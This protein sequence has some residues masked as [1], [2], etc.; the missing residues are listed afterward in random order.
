MQFER[1][2]KN[3]LSVENDRSPQFNK[4]VGQ[5]FY[6][7]MTQ[8]SQEMEASQYRNE[9][10]GKRLILLTGARYE[11]RLDRALK[12]LAEG[13]RKETDLAIA[14]FF[15]A[16]ADLEFRTAANFIELEMFGSAAQ[17]K[18]K[19]SFATDIGVH[20]PPM[21]F[22]TEASQYVAPQP[23]P[24][25]DIK[26]SRP[27]LPRSTGGF[28]GRTAELDR[29]SQSC[30][31]PENNI[32]V[33]VAPGGYGKTMLVEEFGSKFAVATGHDF[34]WYLERSFYSQG[35]DLGTA[36]SDP[37]FEAA[38]SFFGLEMPTGHFA[39]K[40]APLAA[41][42]ARSP[43]LLVL[44]GLEPLQEPPGYGGGAI[45]DNGLKLFLRMLAQNNSGLC[46]VTTRI[47]VAE[48]AGHA[49]GSVAVIE[50]GNLEKGDAAK[51]LKSL[52]VKGNAAELSKLSKYVDCNPIA[53]RLLGN[54][55]A[56]RHEGLIDKQEISILQRDTSTGDQVRRLL[57]KYHDWL[58]PE[59][60]F[61]LSLTGF[62]RRP[63]S[64]NEANHLS[65]AL[66]GS[67]AE[68]GNGADELEVSIERLSSIG[69]LYQSQDECY[70]DCH[71]L[72]REYEREISQS[73]P[74]FWRAGHVALAEFL[75]GV[76]P[77]KPNQATEMFILYDA[78]QHRVD[79]GMHQYAWE[80][81]ISP[82]LWQG[83]YVSTS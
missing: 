36:S 21:R 4:A 38:Y 66:H 48:L 60:L 73:T 40:A 29:L 23:L 5:A 30:R 31:T 27:K 59:D 70:L 47:S 41:M 44:D 24:K 6:G 45:R 19:R 81:I 82:R 80:N 17:K 9:V 74:V 39:N 10:L 8:T 54:L 49:D 62:F 28:F 46:I 78:I 79:A 58:R 83:A 53:L 77:N 16:Q 33:V 20:V 1:A 14:L 76:V 25:P 67:G 32:A 37:F 51:M 42:L 71:P 34:N 69:L 52:G 64:L 15:L 56:F 57:Q 13:A 11:H 7:E 72:I 3:W 43:G 68:V 61:V 35:I 18:A 65:A 12:N 22:D 26:F 55:L 75:E 50:L 2:L 63:A